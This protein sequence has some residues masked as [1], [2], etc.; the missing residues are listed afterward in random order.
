MAAEGPALLRRDNELPGEARSVSDVVV[1]IILGQ[2]QHILGQQLGLGD[3]RWVNSHHRGRGRRR[4]LNQ[5][6]G[7]L[8]GFFFVFCLFRAAY[9]GS[10]ARG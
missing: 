10:Q 1:L 4:S 8:W 9:G 3:K 7:F 5:I 2:T 6:L